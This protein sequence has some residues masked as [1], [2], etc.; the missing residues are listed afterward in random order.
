MDTLNQDLVVGSL[1]NAVFAHNS[2]AARD[3]RQRPLIGPAVK[4]KMP[5]GLY[6]C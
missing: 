1:Q 4:T 2:V 6:V 5:D 3:N